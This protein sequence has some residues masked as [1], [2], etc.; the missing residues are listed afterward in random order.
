MLLHQENKEEEKEKEI[1]EIASQLLHD[2]LQK[3]VNIPI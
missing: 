1:Y 2:S 3:Y